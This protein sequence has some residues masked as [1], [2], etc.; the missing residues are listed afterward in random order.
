MTWTR[1][2]PTIPGEYWFLIKGKA[3]IG[4]LKEN[5]LFDT[6]FGVGAIL[7]TPEQWNDVQYSGPLVPPP[8]NTK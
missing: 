1:E 3:F 4:R 6:R 8:V 2:K 5:G 7:I